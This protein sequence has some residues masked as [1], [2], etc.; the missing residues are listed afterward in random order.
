MNKIDVAKA[1]YH[2]ANKGVAQ[3]LDNNKRLRA[4]NRAKDA[5]V[6]CKG[7]SMDVTDNLDTFLPSG[8]GEFCGAPCYIRNLRSYF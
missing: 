8:G 5:K 4:M 7:C 1:F 2:G 6:A 3:A